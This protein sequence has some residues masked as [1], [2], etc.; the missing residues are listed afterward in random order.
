MCA[1][2][3][4][5]VA[6][7]LQPAALGKPSTLTI[8]DAFTG[9][10]QTS[11]DYV[12]KTSWQAASASNHGRAVPDASKT[13]DGTWHDTTQDTFFDTETTYLDLHFQGTGISIY[14]II[15]NSLPPGVGAKANYSFYMDGVPMG[16]DF[17]HEPDGSAIDFY[18]NI[19][20]FST[21]SLSGGSHTIR[22]IPN[23]GAGLNDS[24]LLLFD[25]AVVT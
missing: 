3:W 25:Y 14:C 22:V 4:C 2:R 9:D 15:G 16:P 5:C 21:S 10:T 11:L 20:V 8:D 6:L 18:Y 1:I 17:L 7:L 23:G 19:S 24:V 12:P 13:L